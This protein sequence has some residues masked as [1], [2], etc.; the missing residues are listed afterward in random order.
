MPKCCKPGKKPLAG[1][2][3]GSSGLATAMV[4][5]NGHFVYIHR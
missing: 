3:I 1:K 2:V 4:F 5:L